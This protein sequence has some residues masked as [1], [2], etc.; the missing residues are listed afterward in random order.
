[1]LVRIEPL[2]SFIAARS[3]VSSIGATT[4]LTRR[5]VLFGYLPT[6]I[7]TLY[8]AVLAAINLKGAGHMA[9]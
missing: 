9:N 3:L 1:M 4:I 7:V 8:I 5:E 6:E 2:K